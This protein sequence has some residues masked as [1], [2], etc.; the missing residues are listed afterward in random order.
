MT[1]KPVLDTID[2]GENGNKFGYQEPLIQKIND[3]KS[4]T[5]L[6][7]VSVKTG[8][9]KTRVQLRYALDSLAMGKNVVIYIIE[10][11]ATSQQFYK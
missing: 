9:G 1:N 7:A 10:W 4:N 5:G 8:H 11:D 6:I 3:I 2:Y